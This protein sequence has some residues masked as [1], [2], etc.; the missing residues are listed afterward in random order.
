MADYTMDDFRRD[1]A[2]RLGKNYQAP[3]PRA[4]KPKR[5]AVGRPESWE[6]FV[7]R[8]VTSCRARLAEL[9]QRSP[10]DVIAC[11]WG[12]CGLHGRGDLRV[13]EPRPGLLLVQVNCPAT[14]RC[15]GKGQVTVGFMVAHYRLVLAE[16]DGGAA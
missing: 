16:Y 9:E 7:R 3:R 15:E 14:C 12:F 10:A 8:L 2:R 4:P 1:R 11:P 5:S 6:T 13:S